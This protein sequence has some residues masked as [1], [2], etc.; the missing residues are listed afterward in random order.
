M[1]SGVRRHAVLAAGVV[2]MGGAGTA[3]LAQSGNARDSRI[4]ADQG[5]LPSAPLG[6]DRQAAAGASDTMTVLNRSKESL[7]VAVKARPWTQSSSGAVS[8]NRRSTLGGVRVT[9]GD[10]TLA[11]GESRNVDVAFG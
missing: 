8:P 2:A 10:F 6:V 5:G 9:G 4:A 11:P 1:G 7:T 3:V